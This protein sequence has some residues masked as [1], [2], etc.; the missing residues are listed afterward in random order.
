[1][2]STASFSKVPVT[3]KKYVV[4]EKGNRML[5]FW[6]IKESAIPHTRNSTKSSGSLQHHGESP[7]T[8]PHMPGSRG[9]LAPKLETK[10]VSNSSSGSDK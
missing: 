10:W 8:S 9:R 6:K 2:Y 5:T 3:E 7:T 1:M 4:S